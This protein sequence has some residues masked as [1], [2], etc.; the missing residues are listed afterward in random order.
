MIVLTVISDISHVG[1]FRL[2]ASCA[3]QNLALKTFVCNQNEYENKN[4]RSKDE[5]IKNFL[6]ELDEEEI[7]LFTDGYDTLMLAGEEEILEKFRAAKTSLLFSAEADCFPDTSIKHLYPPATD[8][9][10]Q[11]LNSGGYIGKAGMIKKVLSENIS[12]VESNFNWS[13]QYSWAIRYLRNTDRIKLD[14]GCHIFTAFSNEAIQNSLPED[15]KT[16][17]AY[18]VAFYHWFHTHYEISNGRIFNK[19]TGTWPC[20]AHFNGQ[21][22]VFAATYPDCMNMLFEQIPGSK[23]LSIQYV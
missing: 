11:F 10:Y 20:N 3:L 12:D 23:R 4:H 18:N 15:S 19:I 21:T 9:P 7:V 13:N 8:G 17:E 22:S 2:K 5:L 14:S 16:D 6:N 1:F